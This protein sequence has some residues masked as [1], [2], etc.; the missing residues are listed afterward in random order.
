MTQMVVV[1]RLIGVDGEA[2]ED[3]VES[4][5]NNLE[6]TSE[7]EIEKKYYLAHTVG[8]VSGFAVLLNILSKVQ[9]L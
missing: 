2:T 7:A 4:L 9:N 6:P 8:Q 1:F 5:S 3:R